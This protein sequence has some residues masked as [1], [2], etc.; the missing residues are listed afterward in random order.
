MRS[1]KYFCLLLLL[2]G[3]VRLP[4][5][6]QQPELRQRP[7]Y[8][9]RPGDILQLQYRLTPEFNQSVTVQPDGYIAINVGGEIQV[10]GLNM[11]QAHD[12]IVA[13][14][15]SRLKD[16]ELT[17]VL[18]EF[19]RPYVVVA[20]EVSKPGQIE[21]RDQMSALSAIMMAG[22]F[23]NGAK[24]GQVIVFRKFNDNLAEVRELNL[25]HVTK[26]RQ[27]EHDL[28]LQPGDIVYV[29][30]DRIS[31]L[32][33]YMQLTNLGFYASPTDFAK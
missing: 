8:L 14:E 33:H 7:R 17:L 31:R 6:A 1:K 20:G 16:P 4:L 32:Q 2:A 12:L 18:E 26:T 13:K 21:I 28:A 25:T 19:T 3:T 11:T 27:L 24:S 30:H 5:L 10:A 22:G 23:T 29:P 9:L 15:S